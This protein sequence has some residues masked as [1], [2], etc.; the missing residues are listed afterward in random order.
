MITDETIE[1][2]REQADIVEIVGEHVK[3]RRAGA[4]FRGPCPFHGG[5][6]PNFSVSPRRNAYHCFKCGVS[7]DA[8]GFVREHLGMDFAE[9]VRYVAAR[10]GV[11]VK[12]TASPRDRQERDPREPLWEALAAAAEFFREQLW[13]TDDGSA[14]RDYL[15]SRGID[16]EAAERFGLGWAPR[17][18][19]QLRAHL[20]TLGH[21]DAR[22]IEAGL[23]VQREE[24][25]EP[26]GRFWSRLIF[27]I[28]DASGR[29]CGFGG[30]VIGQGEPKYLN[31]PESSVYSKSQLL[32]GLSWARH[33]IRKADRA[34]VVEG[35]FDA[36]RLALAGVDEVIAPLGTALTE[37]QAAM[38][39]KLSR[40]VFLLYDSDEAG[41]K[42]TFRAGLELLRV[43]VSARV[44]SLPKGEDPDTFVRERGAAGLEQ[45]MAQAIDIFD[46]QVQLLERRGWFAELHK[47]RRAIDKLLPTIRATA[48]PLTRELYVSRLAEKAGVER[49]VVQ[50]E[51]AQ[52]ARGARGARAQPSSRADGDGP[53]RG[54]MP[55]AVPAAPATSG[56]DVVFDEPRRNEREER[57]QQM[58]QRFADRRG[59]RGRRAVDWASSQAVPRVV[60]E[61]PGG[62]AERVLVRAMLHDRG[63]VDAVAERFGPDAFR[64]PHY[65]AIFQALLD[66]QEEEL[67]A[68]AERLSD[69]V[70][71]TMDQLLDEPLEDGG[72]E[73]DASFV[74]LRVR[75]LD[76]AMAEIDRRLL[77]PERRPSEEETTALTREKQRLMEE[78]R[79]LLPTR[80]NFGKAGW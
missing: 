38:L 49:E 18:G 1:R 20:N 29:C 69:D 32:Y 9:A 21:D 10:A 23:L 33:P 46:R 79:L 22:Q 78:R 68:V 11:E 14:A 5:K 19:A 67:A 57:Y 77:D 60:R 27:P 31:S 34:L 39:A 3:L 54:E 40:N 6:N 70:A 7:G 28:L 51:A 30:R 58:R 42:A 16:R 41:L 25:G 76:D 50:R 64:H 66:G 44:V 75:E 73:V 24:Q 62:G 17:D 48:D 47:K 26:R 4:D 74:R 52:P 71:V 37:S 56:N 8:I 61:V 2:V 59:S 65:R 53:G 80:R 43:G 12:E 15:A 63:Q 36:I 55:R 35:Y 45:M 13:E 72:R